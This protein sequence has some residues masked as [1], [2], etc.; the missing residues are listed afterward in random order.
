[1]ST[2]VQQQLSRLRA[3]TGFTTPVGGAC[4]YAAL[5]S[6]TATVVYSGIDPSDGTKWQCTFVNNEGATLPVTVGVLCKP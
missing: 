4:G 3:P 6:V 2:P 5:F 1:M